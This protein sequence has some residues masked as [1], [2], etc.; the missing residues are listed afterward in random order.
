[1]K[2]KKRTKK[3]EEEEEEEEEEESQNQRVPAL[4]SRLASAVL[5]RQ[6]KPHMSEGKSRQIPSSC[7]N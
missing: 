1:L 5:Q 4:L 7:M 2:K 6:Q 3:K